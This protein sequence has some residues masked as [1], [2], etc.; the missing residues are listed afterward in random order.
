MSPLEGNP[1]PFRAVRK[2]DKL[3]YSICVVSTKPL[4][5]ITSESVETTVKW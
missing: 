3:G 1:R 2:S 4:N 5:S